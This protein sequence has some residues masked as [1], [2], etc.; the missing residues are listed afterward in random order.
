M[1][2][3]SS[4]TAANLPIVAG[5]VSASLHSSSPAILM[6]LP[7]RYLTQHSGNK[8]CNNLST[9]NNTFIKTMFCSLLI[10]NFI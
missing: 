7:N 6:K 10:V 8:K 5:R 1:F 2:R 9:R 3:D 4:R